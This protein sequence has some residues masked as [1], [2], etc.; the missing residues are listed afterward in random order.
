MTQS[1]LWKIIQ[2][3]NT[4][5]FNKFLLSGTDCDVTE[6]LQTPHQ[7]SGDFPVHMMCRHGKLGMLKTS[8][9]CWNVTLSPVN[10]DG[11]TPLHEAACNGRANVVKYLLKNEV[12]VNPLKKAGWTPLMMACTKINNLPCV[13]ALVN[14]GAKLH[15]VNKDG[16]NCFHIACRE[17]D[18]EIIE[19]LFATE[20]CIA[21]TV[22]TNGR[23]P[24]HTSALHG[25]TEV[26]KFL[27]NT[28]KSSLETR[29]VCGSTVLM[30]GVRSGNVA[31]VDYIA[32]CGLSLFD[33]D[34]MGRNCL[35]IAAEANQSVSIQ[36]LVESYN[37]DIN[38]RIKVENGFKGQTALHLAYK[39]DSVEAVECLIKL[40]ADVSALDNTGRKP[41]EIKS[42][43]TFKF[44]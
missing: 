32:S 35:H 38:E 37:C 6:L 7:K 12:N 30:D 19:Y 43:K 14:A 36:H 2:H 8:H 9:T 44:S 21:S 33:V 4:E 13:T 20:P 22:S 28:A 41:H 18:M 29:D 15:L 24:L 34:S 40:G 39:A 31:I 26:L 27:V 23:T 10:L 5:E 25:K 1:R 17:G 3:S 42:K 11:K 16:W